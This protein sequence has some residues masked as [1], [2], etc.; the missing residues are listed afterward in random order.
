VL[1]RPPVR[2]L[3]RH[4]FTLCTALSLL[5]GVAVCVL[6]VRSVDRLEA[7]GR[8]E[9]HASTAGAPGGARHFGSFG[10][11]KEKSPWTSAPPKHSRRRRGFRVPAITCN[12]G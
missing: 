1:K 2:R 11:K 8:N 3:A 4:L 9:I 7:I 10:R 6:W 5:L 12:A